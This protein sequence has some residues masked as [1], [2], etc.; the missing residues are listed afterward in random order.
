MNWRAAMILV[1][2]VAAIASGWSAWRQHAEVDDATTTSD[3]SDYILEDFQLV[4]L[5]SD[6]RE[7]F[8]LRA[9]HLHRNPVDETMS[10]REPVF[11]LPEEGSE[12]YWDL[13]AAT[14]WISAD[15]EEMRLRG[16]VV[17]V[18][19]PAGTREMRMETEALDVFPG[20]RRARSDAAVTI[21]QPGTTMRGT[22][23]EADLADKRFQ[24]TSK[25]Q[26][27]YVPTRR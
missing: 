23:M 3:R 11:L 19:D 18:S 10:L 25:V 8:T 22:G 13:R 9:P 12:L 1:L 21:T 24:L 17:V 15:S 20:Q 6:G 16:E 26:T 27:R 5:D 4:S 2:L 14:G 7:A